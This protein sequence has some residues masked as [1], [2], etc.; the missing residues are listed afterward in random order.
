MFLRWR[1]YRL[2]GGLKSYRAEIAR[3]Y[4]ND[5]TDTPRNEVIAYLG[6]WRELWAASPY[7]RAEFSEQVEKKL[8]KLSLSENDKSKIRAAINN[9]I[10][11]SQT[12]RLKILREM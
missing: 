10:S 11:K 1:E 4:R 5:L 8:S 2:S 7:R 3:S 6:T 9:R 12:S